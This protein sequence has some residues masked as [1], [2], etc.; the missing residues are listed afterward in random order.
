MKYIKLLS[1]AVFLIG[2]VALLIFFTQGENGGGNA[3]VT[4]SI[5]KQFE[6]EIVGLCKEGKWSQQGYQNLENK[7]R[8]FAKDG[9]IELGERDALCLYLYTASCEGLLAYADKLFQQSS[10]P[11]DKVTYVE[12]AFQFLKSQ[13]GGSNSN[14]TQGLNMIHEYKTV[15]SCSSISSEA[16]YSHPLQ[17]FNGGAATAMA[18]RIKNLRYYK[19]HFSKN[20]TLRAKVENLA[21]NLAQK[22]AE[23]YM[24]LEK[25]VETNYYRLKQ[26]L[27][28]WQA[29]EQTQSDYER[30]KVISTNSSATSKLSNFINGNH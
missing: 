7:I 9:N 2:A 13:N 10:Y 27:S 14:L 17:P 23:Y 8:T 4:S 6:K 22:E 30:F 21:S 11:P 18:G 24:N 15:V 12:S 16:H 3:G 1:I 5:A 19:S 28:A 26:S 29:L 20:P 25:C